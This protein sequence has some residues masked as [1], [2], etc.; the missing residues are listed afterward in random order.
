MSFDNGI[1]YSV[2]SGYSKRSSA[3]EFNFNY[4]GTY[5]AVRVKAVD[6]NPVLTI[7]INGAVHLSQTLVDD[8]YTIFTLPAGQKYVQ[9]IEQ[10]TIYNGVTISGCWLKSIIL[11]PSKYSKINQGNVSYGLT[12]IGDSITNSTVING[13]PSLFKSLDSKPV[14]IL[15]GA[16]AKL[17]NFSANQ[18][19]WVQ[20][21]VD[22]FANVTTTKKLIIMIGIN[23]FSG[24]ASAASFATWHSNF[25][26]AINAAD[27][28][29]QIF[30]ISPLTTTTENATLALYRTNISINCIAR[31]TYT[32]YIDGYP[33]CDIATDFSD[34]IHPTTAGHLKVHNAIDGIIL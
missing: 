20:Y 16:F 6:S 10:G 17:Q 32:T 21:I 22:S 33:I 19:A 13:Y 5:L 24:G 30:C 18:A 8:V 28:T 12:F 29:I 34:G 1:V 7:L 9:L 26:T 25:L 15:G 31:P 14:K 4:S 11:E 23:D 2:E 27:S 3:S